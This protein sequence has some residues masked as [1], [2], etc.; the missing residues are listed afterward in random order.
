MELI[1]AVGNEEDTPGDELSRFP[2]FI[3]HQGCVYDFFYRPVNS[4]RAR[5]GLL[6]R[7][8]ISLSSLSSSSQNGHSGDNNGFDSHNYQFNSTAVSSSPRH[9]LEMD[10]QLTQKY[11]EETQKRQFIKRMED[12]IVDLNSSKYLSSLF[13]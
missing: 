10:K 1:S 4:S 9:R 2:V 8:H 12:G 7:R 11:I 5:S 3:D 6:P 13:G